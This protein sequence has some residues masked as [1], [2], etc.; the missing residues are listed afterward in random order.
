MNL[1]SQPPSPPSVLYGNCR[2]C[3]KART[4]FNW[5]HACESQ[6]FQENFSNWTS[7]NEQIDAIVRTSQENAKQG[8]D[9]LE[10]IP[11]DQFELIT[12]SIRGGYGAVYKA[13]W[14]EGPRSVWDEISLEWRR[15]GP[16]KVALKRLD[17]SCRMSREFLE[18]VSMEWSDETEVNR[19]G[20]YHSM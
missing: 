18:K 5:C 11:F 14:L 3:G 16:T 9:F 13:I 1:P 2:D 6:W 20:L 8:G 15:L 4:I 12:Y 7:G 10:W 17:N 19:H